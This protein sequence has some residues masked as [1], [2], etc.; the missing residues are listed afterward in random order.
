MINLLKKF[1][2]G[3]K[4]E[5]LILLLLTALYF[6][7]Y[8]NKPHN[9]SDKIAALTPDGWKLYESVKKFTPENLYEHINGR[10]E[11]YLAYNVKSLTTATFEKESD[12]S[13]FMEL[14]IFDMET[15][16]NAFGI[17]SVERSGDESFLDLGRKSYYSDSSIFIWKGKFYVTIVTSSLSDQLLPSSLDIGRKVMGFL[18]DSGE[19]VWGLSALPQR[20]L[21]PGSEKYFKV[22]AL[23]LDFLQNTYTVEYLIKG[24]KISAFLSRHISSESAA[25]SMTRYSEY[26]SQY[27]KGV[28]IRKREGM[29]FLLC[30][31]DGSFDVV[32]QKERL[33]GGVYSVKDSSLALEAAFKLWTQIDFE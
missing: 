25:E 32:F 18:S 10:A 14:S 2:F 17:F 20:N 3:F 26:A 4:S 21:V 29:E 15:S 33:V 7:S 8:S 23:G 30:D 27:G 16:T 31:M 9:I 19:P 5:K 13:E 22:D 1:Q 24:I 12:I 11:L 6:L 28:R